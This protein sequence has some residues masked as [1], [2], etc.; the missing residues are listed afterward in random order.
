MAEKKYFASKEPKECVRILEDK[1]DKWEESLVTSGMLDKIKR[2]WAFYHGSFT[3]DHIDPHT[4]T[5]QN[6]FSLP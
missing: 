6:T 4:H 3:D 1:I 5:M 2:S